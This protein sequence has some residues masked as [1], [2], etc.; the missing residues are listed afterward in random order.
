MIVNT[1][2]MSCVIKF[3]GSSHQTVRHAALA[4]LLEL[5]KSQHACVKIGNATGGILMLVTSKYNEES[6]AFASETADQILRNLEK[7]PHNI[8]QMA[9]SGLLEPLLIHLAEGDS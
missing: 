4:L 2:A 1:L 6:D 3:L 5:S 9:E 8:K 7:F